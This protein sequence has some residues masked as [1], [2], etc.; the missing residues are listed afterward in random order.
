MYNTYAV[1]R[2]SIPS[3]LAGEEAT[4]AEGAL[5]YMPQYGMLKN[6]KYLNIIEVDMIHTL[7]RGP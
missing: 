1:P 2:F 5:A 7:C 4:S 6:C 3:S